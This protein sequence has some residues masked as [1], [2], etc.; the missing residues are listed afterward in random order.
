MNR[1]LRVLKVRAGKFGGIETACTIACTMLR[2]TSKP[3]A[4]HAKHEKRAEKSE[5]QKS[6]TQK[7][8][9]P[10]RAPDQNEFS[11]RAPIARAEVFRDFA[12]TIL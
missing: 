9:F 2:N 5:F 8:T 7:C 10:P 3:T 11:S 4:K 12:K 6:S 1:D